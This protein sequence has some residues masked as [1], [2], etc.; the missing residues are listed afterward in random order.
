MASGGL[1]AVLE[2][3][4]IVAGLDDVAVVGQPIEHGGRHFGVAEHLRPIGEGQIGGDQERRVLIELADQV[5]QQLAAGLTERQVAEFV[6]DNEIVTQQLL[7]QSATSTGGLL[8]FQLID[9][10]DQVEEA[11]PG[12]AAD[13]R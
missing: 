9:Q 7:G 13:D 6:D 3:P 11:P 4:A 8:L 12:A 10:I 5:E 1:C 2:A